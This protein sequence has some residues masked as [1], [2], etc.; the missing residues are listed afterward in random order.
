[1]NEEER[2]EEL[3]K[4]MR[5]M[6]ATDA[7]LNIF[8]M[9]ELDGSDDLTVISVVTARILHKG[10]TYKKLDDVLDYLTKE[11]KSIYREIGEQE[12]DTDVQH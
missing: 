4:F 11:I 8:N 10:Y 5:P 9:L 2:N 7:I 3:H 12:D 6:R 1:M